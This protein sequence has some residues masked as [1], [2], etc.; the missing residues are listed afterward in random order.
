[1][2]QRCALAALAVLALI[3]QALGAGTISLSLSQQ[4][5]S[6]GDP[7]VGGLLYFYQAGTTTPQSAFKDAALTLPHPNP[8]TLDASGRVPAFYL[9]DGAIKVRLTDRNGIVQIAEDGL[10]VVGP[11]GGGGG[12]SPIDPTTVIATGDI[13]VRYA[14]GTLSGYVRANGRTIG[15]ASS[16]A[17]ERA[18][19][20]CQALFEFLWN[21]DATLAVSGGHGASAAADWGANKT[22]AL[23]DMRGRVIAGLDDMGNSAASRLTSTYFGTS[24][25]VLGAVGGSQSHTLTV[26]EMPSHAHGVTDPGHTHSYTQPASTGGAEG[27][28]GAAQPSSG[29][30]ATGAG[31]TGISI[32][33]TGGGGPHKIV[34]P[35]V[36]LTVYIKL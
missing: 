21:N 27:G 19:A 32:Q 11:S 8:I 14:T 35:T 28:S 36:L 31:T 5:D 33:S 15:S 2:M 30:A 18:N 34:Q 7:L 23:P 12:G 24:A 6:Q 26:A 17:T 25:T 1:M 16:G 10:L 20:D 4:F 3:A 29:I 22:I 13:K 9:A